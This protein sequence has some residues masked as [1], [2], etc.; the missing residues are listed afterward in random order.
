M[1]R[2]NLFLLLVIGLMILWS[3][4]F[5]WMSAIAISDHAAGRLSNFAIHTRSEIIRSKLIWQQLPHFSSIEIRGKGLIGLTLVQGKDCSIQM[6]PILGSQMKSHMEYDKLV[7]ELPG[8]SDTRQG[9]YTI[10]CPNLKTI[11]LDHTTNTYIRNFKQPSLHIIT[12]DVYPLS[13]TQCSLNDLTL[14]S[15]DDPPSKYIAIDSVNVINRLTLSIAGKGTLILG[16]AGVMNTS[17]HL[18][19]SIDIQAS[20]RIMKQLSFSGI[21]N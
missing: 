1:K 14:S 5:Q 20:S 17:L 12:R 10:T 13:V 2:S 6:D 19:D 9:V 18:S 11:I 7:M 8:F 16:T 15:M 21:A 4:V 3:A